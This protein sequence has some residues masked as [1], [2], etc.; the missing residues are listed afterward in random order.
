MRKK[1]RLAALGALLLM[2]AG[3][4]FPAR[5]QQAEGLPG[6]E[7]LPS[8]QLPEGFVVSWGKEEADPSQRYR[9]YLPKGEGVSYQYQQERV[10]EEDEQGVTLEY[11]YGEQVEIS[12]LPLEGSGKPDFFLL[13]G[14]TCCLM[15]TS[16]EGISARMPDEDVRAAAVT[17]STLKARSFTE[18]EDAQ[19]DT[20]IHVTGK[21]PGNDYV[22]AYDSAGNKLATMKFWVE[23]LQTGEK[24]FAFCLEPED[25]TPKSGEWYASVKQAENAGLSQET[26]QQMRKI[27]YYGYGGP[28]NLFADDAVGLVTTHLALGYVYTGKTKGYRLYEPFLQQ[29]ESLEMPY[30]EASLTQESLTGRLNAEGRLETPVTT[31]EAFGRNQFYFDLP[32]QVTIHLTTGQSQTGGR[33][34][35]SG[36][37]SFYFTAPAGCQESI[38]AEGIR[39]TYQEPELYLVTPRHATRQSLLGVD[40]QEG[41]QSISL[42]V[43]WE[44][45]QG[46]VQVEKEDTQ[47]NPLAGAEFALTARE[48]ILLP[49]G[50]IKTPAGTRLGTLTT[51]GEGR[52]TFTG[53]DPGSYLVT[54]TKPPAGY[55]PAEA[56][57]VTL[58]A[59]DSL[60]K[61]LTFVDQENQ[62][63]LIKRK[64]GTDTPLK[65]AVFQVWNVKEMKKSSYTTDEKGEIL[66]RKLAPGTYQY[67]EVSAPAGYL[68]DKTVYSFVIGEDGRPTDSSYERGHEIANACTRLEL[69]KVN[70]STGR[71]LEG[72]SLRLTDASGKEVAR[73]ESKEESQVLE[74]LEPGEYILEE[75]KAPAGYLKAQ[76]VRFSL[77]AEEGTQ[78]VTM[79]NYPYGSLKVSKTIRASEIIWAHG[80]PTFFFT[81]EGKDLNGENHRYHGYVRFTREEIDSCTDSQGMAA[82]S[83]TFEHLP[84]GKEYTVTEE[85]VKDYRFVSVSGSGDVRIEGEKALVDLTKKPTGQQVLFCNEK[86]RY[87]GFKHN[88]LKVNTFTWKEN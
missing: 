39:G 78:R 7:E 1:R 8:Y 75:L 59:P 45:P 43:N 79:E 32:S 51:D 3:A 22:D 10:L 63:K 48:D 33:C 87:D 57:K 42:S 77:K 50:E 56:Q 81:V 24:M 44:N 26:I 15:S 37:Q 11:G 72:A 38:Q 52:G 27:L 83:W 74:A 19:G 73:W 16:P 49:S 21:E 47:G 18:V 17:A 61:T 30:G 64:K 20:T 53:L 62:V 54:E 67:Q 66:L 31:L 5:A 76:P 29:L 4:A 60:K 85:P 82:L 12:A 80:D 71:A 55:L 14:E 69:L 2:A 88:D 6:L 36:G 70:G 41:S 58:A 65:G 9:L 46:E 13:E 35:V 28:G 40:W 86:T 68:A 34:M 84:P 23:N 25:Y